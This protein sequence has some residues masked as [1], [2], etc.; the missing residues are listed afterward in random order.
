MYS[1]AE[2]T[3]LS[4]RIAQV[5]HI[6]TYRSLLR[7]HGSKRAGRIILDKQQLAES[8]VYELLGKMSAEAI[9]VQTTSTSN[10]LTT[11]QVI[12]TA[13]VAVKKK[14]QNLRNTLQFVGRTL[15]TS[16]S[17][18]QTSYIQTASTAIS[19]FVKS[20]AAW[21]KLQ[22]TILYQSISR[23]LSG[24]RSASMSSDP[25]TVQDNSSEITRS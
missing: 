1:I 19:N 13:I 9:Q 21:A 10:A 23:K 5:S 17:R 14:H 24:W 6:D 4:K 25:S 3:A 12:N 2:R 20:K 18:L 8:L 11:H 22:I 15:K 7:S 16:S